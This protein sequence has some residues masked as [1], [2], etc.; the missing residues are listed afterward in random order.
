MAALGVALDATGCVTGGTAGTAFIYDVSDATLFHCAAL[1][2]HAAVVLLVAKLVGP[3]RAAAAARQRDSSGLVAR[4]LAE[5]LSVMRPS[6]ELPF[7]AH[8]ECIERV[9][10][11]LHKLR[12]IE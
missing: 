10:G 6:D 12:V 11:V 9:C 4:E 2:G 5:R 8:A 3:Q 7:T 1:H